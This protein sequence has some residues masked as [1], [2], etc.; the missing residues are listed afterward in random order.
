MTVEM[1]VEQQLELCVRV[2]MATVL[3]GIVGFERERSGHSAGLR[4]HMLVGLGSA[5]F[6]VLSLFAFGRGDPGRVAAQIV[7]GIGFIGAGAII[8]RQHAKRM[9]HGLTTASGIW[10]VAAIGMACGAGLYIVGA[11]ST[12]LVVFLLS[13]LAV[14]SQRLNLKKDLRPAPTT[15]AAPNASNEQGT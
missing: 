12:L 8:Q 1:T 11:F 13:A 10:A 5:L 4:T 3:S 7:T 15:P 14:V 9:L 2:F 6:T